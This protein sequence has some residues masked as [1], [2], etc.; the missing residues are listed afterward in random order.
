MEMVW[1]VTQ[2]RSTRTCQSC[3]LL[4]YLRLSCQTMSNLLIRSGQR[5]KIMRF[6]HR[7]LAVDEHIVN[8]FF[9]NCQLVL[10]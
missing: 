4:Q 8:V 7:D 3:S 6:L 10:C 5:N 2:R 9:T 1:I